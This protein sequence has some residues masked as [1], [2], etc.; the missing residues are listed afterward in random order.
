M[1]RL[2]NIPNKHRS[3]PTKL[4][5]REK[6]SWCTR[7]PSHASSGSPSELAYWNKSKHCLIKW[8]KLWWIHNAYPPPIYCNDRI[9]SAFSCLTI[10]RQRTILFFYYIKNIFRARQNIRFEVFWAEQ[11]IFL[12]VIMYVFSCIKFIHKHK[13][14]RLPIILKCGN[15]IENYEIGY[16]V[17]KLTQTILISPKC[18]HQKHKQI[19]IFR[20]V[21]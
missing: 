5:R 14:M 9:S 8:V 17:I 6:L 1:S 3:S 12:F 20:H 15:I 4:C 18:N 16:R 13:Q 10:V 2:C 21:S 19:V 7:C 11:S